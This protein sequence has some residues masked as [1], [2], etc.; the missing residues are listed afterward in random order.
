MMI[1]VECLSE[2]NKIMRVCGWEFS[3]NWTL[4]LENQLNYGILNSAILNRRTI[5][6]LPRT[7]DPLHET[8]EF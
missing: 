3:G 5:C 4:E 8:H 1:R 2:D 7:P 6:K